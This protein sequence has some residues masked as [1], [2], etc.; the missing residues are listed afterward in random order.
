MTQEA[1]PIR[2]R[3]PAPRAVIFDLGGTLVHWADWE[4]GAAAKWSF[5]YDA[6]RRAAGNGGA[7]T[8]EDFI[9]AMRG[10]EK[11]HWERVDR[12]RWSG[13]PTGLV[14]EG[15]RRLDLALGEDVLIATM[16]GYARAVAGWSTV[17]PDS[18]DTLA[19]LRAR[20]YRLNG[21]NPQR[22]VRTVLYERPPTG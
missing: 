18:R 17:Y 19:L 4:S 2:S 10:A 20:G 3:V 16:D 7:P 5:A 6:T 15:L 1:A 21:S 8:R 13:P 9:A 14:A 22:Y 11:A 12:E